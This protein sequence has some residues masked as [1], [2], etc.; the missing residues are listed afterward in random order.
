MEKIEVKP[1]GADMTDDEREKE[2]DFLKSKSPEE[3]RDLFKEV[4]SPT[5]SKFPS[6]AWP[7]VATGDPRRVGADSR[8][9]GSILTN[10]A[11]W[12]AVPGRAQPQG[13]EDVGHGSEPD[14]R[15]HAE[16]RVRLALQGVHRRHLEPGQHG[17]VRPVSPPARGGGRDPRHRG[18]HLLYSRYRS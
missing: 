17:G 4:R 5:L 18:G 10:G 13:L 6:L 16:A 8:V 1:A 2:A 14:R 15:V 7:A 9:C 12:V 11:W 3:L